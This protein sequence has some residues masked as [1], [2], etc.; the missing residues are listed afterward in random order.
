MIFGS[1]SIAIMISLSMMSVDL[2][3]RLAVIG[4]VF[5]FIALML[6][7]VLEQIL[8]GCNALVHFGVFPCSPPNF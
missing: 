2:V 4:F 6:L 3:R 5:S 1:L 8:K 7:P